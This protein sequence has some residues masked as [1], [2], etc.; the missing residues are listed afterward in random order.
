M[1]STPLFTMEVDDSAVKVLVKEKKDTLRTWEKK[2]N[3]G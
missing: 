1:I 3:D 2:W